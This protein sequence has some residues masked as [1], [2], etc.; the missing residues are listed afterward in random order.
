M[1]NARADKG[2][3]RAPRK[4]ISAPKPKKTL[5]LEQRARESAKRKG[6]RQAVDARDEAITTAVVAVAAQQ[7]VTNGRFAASTRKALYMLG[8]NR[9]QHSLFNAAVAAASTGSSAFPHMVLPDSPSALVAPRCPASTSTRKP[10]ASSESA[11]PR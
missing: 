2:K 3:P 11:R 9:S 7:E 1:T 6:R 8:L 4:P 10:P 5:T